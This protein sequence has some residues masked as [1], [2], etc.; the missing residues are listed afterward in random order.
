M[1]TSEFGYMAILWRITQPNHV[2]KKSA[3]FLQ[4]VFCCFDN[5]RQNISSCFHY[6]K[7]FEVST[8][9]HFNWNRDYTFQ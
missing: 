8:I 5:R 9:G 4:I 2:A 7:V 6:P 3:I 1:L